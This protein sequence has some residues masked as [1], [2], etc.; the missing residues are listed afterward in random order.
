M[1]TPA[2]RKRFEEWL[3]EVTGL[4]TAAGREDRVIRW[5]ESWV[6]RRKNLRLSADA[7]GNLTITRVGARGGRPIF[8]TAHLDHPAFVIRRRLGSKRLELEFRGGVDNAYFA[9]AKIELFDADDRRFNAVLERL[10]AKAQPFKRVTARLTRPADTLG[11]GDIGRWKLPGRLPRIDRGRLH[12]P[13]CDDLAAVVAALA[14]L[15][16]V[17]RRA[18]APNMGVL[19]TRAEEI[20]FVGTL[21][22]CVEGSVPRTARLLCLENSRSF[23]ESP[24]GAGP[25]LRVG[26]RL[27]VFS[28]E[29]TNHL[30][31]ILTDHADR[32]PAFRWQ[33]KLM[34]GGACEA[35][36]FSAFGYT[37]TCLCL[38]LGNYH[39]MA[40]IDGVRAGKRP[41]RV[42]AE[43]I[44]IDDFHHLVEA[45]VVCATRMDAARTPPL[46][47]R[48]EG[49][50]VRGRHVLEA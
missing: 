6:A 34:P 36:A 43:H 3:L 47:K 41:A 25:I 7:A 44:A 46:K 42:R 15:D 5:V 48:L 4:P 30:G 11:I 33:R 20:G 45:L 40:D 13:A 24:I 2:Q 38:P 23:P 16:I 49:L 21:A 27:S 35:T 32:H 17:R 31:V 14:T 10:D 39:N 22:A 26:D 50:L 28:P 18:S 9:N 19:L 12:A 8:L 1:L 29:L 37:S